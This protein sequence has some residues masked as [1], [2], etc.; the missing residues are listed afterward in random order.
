M[1]AVIF[2]ADGHYGE[3]HG[4]GIYKDLTLGL[5]KNCEEYNIELIHL[6]VTGHEG[7]GH[8]N[9]YYGVDDI[10]EVIYNR[11]KICYQIGRAHV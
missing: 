3:R 2:H 11:E 1:K 9:Y 10:N 6:T 5:K 4:L 8:Q 7:W